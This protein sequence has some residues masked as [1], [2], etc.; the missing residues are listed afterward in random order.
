MNR[1]IVWAVLLLVLSTIRISAQGRI[2]VNCDE[3]TLSDTGFA[4]EPN[5]TPIFA[6]NVANFF[7][8]GGPGDFLVYS[9][10]FGL[11]Q[12]SLATTMTNAGHSWTIDASLPFTLTTLQAYDAVYLAGL[13]GSGSTNA[14]TLIAYVAGGGNVY[15]AGGTAEMPGAAAEAAAWAP[16]LNAFGLG[17]G[18]PYN[19]ASTSSIVS[20]HPVFSGVPSLYFYDGNDVLITGGGDPRV[21]TA[22]SPSNGN[23]FGFFNGPDLFQVNQ[24]TA[25]MTVNGAVGTRIKLATAGGAAGTL[26]LSST[27]F[28]A[29]IDIAVTMPQAPV[30]VGAGG[31]VL[32]DGQIVNLDITAPS[33]FLVNGGFNGLPLFGSL[34]V[35]YSLPPGS[36]PFSAQ[37]VV[38]DG[39]QLFG[40]A[41]SQPVRIVP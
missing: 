19:G 14:A 38:L 12:S 9:A 2:V 29:T 34:S 39:A 26:T 28:A 3:Y 15:L 24:P 25:T 7:T 6:L 13:P 1:S 16:F 10:N 31:I 4:V 23:L 37:L 32:T 27:I 30:A 22:G 17:F 35:P 21:E 40:F 8:G 11:T 20:N 33:L 5:Y 41:L 18:S 36:A